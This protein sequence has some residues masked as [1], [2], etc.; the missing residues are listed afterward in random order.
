[1]QIWMEGAD[2][3]SQINEKY[4]IFRRG[5]TVVDLG[6]A[7]GSWSQ[8]AVDRTRP[9]GRVLGI[10]MIPA[11]PPKGASTIQG[12]F[13]D[14]G[15][16]EE[17]KKFLR[18]PEKGRLR[19]QRLLS[20]G[21]PEDE[22]EDVP[23]GEMEDLGYI[24]RERHASSASSTPSSE[25]LAECE[26]GA[27]KMTRKER[28]EASGKTVD[29]VLSDMSAPWP[30]TSGF[31]NRSLSMPYYRMMNTSGIAFRDHAGSMVRC[32]STLNFPPLRER[33]D[34]EPRFQ[35]LCN[36]ALRFATDTLRPG[37]GSFICKFYQ[38]AEDKALEMKLKKLFRNVHREKPESSRSDSRE[39]FFVALR[40]KE[41]VEWEHVVGEGED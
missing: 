32:L 4:N 40:R 28:D 15:V 21:S 11:S 35:D 14:L 39:G 36:A 33:S 34:S 27:R 17:V 1:M 37:S 26:R 9:N 25:A 38:G 8:V 10:D 19:R 6:Y 18:D 29:V 31:W 20:D 22:D 16:R 30:Q 13:L 41:G 2:E 7:P 3:T 5:Q 12:N 24:D 23:E